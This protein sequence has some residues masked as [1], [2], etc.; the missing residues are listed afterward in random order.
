MLGGYAGKMLF[1]NLSEG[2]IREEAL[3]EEIGR[4]FIGGYG[5]GIRI[6]YERMQP[7]TDALGDGNMLGFVAG[8]LTGTSVPGSGRYGVVTKSPLTGAWSESNAGGTFG[9]A[10][11]AAGYD[12]VFFSGIAPKP[13]YLLLQDG[14][15]A[16]NDAGFL[17]GKDTYAT[18]DAIHEAIGDPKARIAS[19]GPAGEARSLLAGIVNEKGRIAARGGAGAVMGSKLLK[20]VAISGG[21]RRIAVANR[22]GLKAAQ[23]RFLD[24]IRNSEF[25]KGLTAAGTGGAVSFLISI[26]DSPVQNW[27]RT[28]SD[29]MPTAARLDSPNMDKYK[30]SPYACQACPIRCGAI[31]EQTEGPFSVAGEMHRPEYE[32]IAA[33]GNLLV[34]DNLEAVIKANDICNRY[35][36][37]TISTGTAIALAMECFEKGLI[38]ARDADGLDL[39]WG[40]AESIVALTEK[41][42][43]REGFGAVLADGPTI[44]AERIGRGAERYAVAVRGK[45]LPFHDPRMSPAGATAL[46]ADAN[47]GHHMANQ[48]AG[49]LENGISIGP[50][51]ALQAPAANPFSDFDRKGDI[52]ATGF[53]YHQLLD[54]AGLCALYTVNTTPP[55][56]A[57]LIAGVTGWD[58]GWEE[59]L[60]AGRRVLTLRQA[61]NARE[62]ITPDQVRLPQRIREELLPVA[63]GAPPG[64]DF[65]ALRDGYY[66]AMGWDTRTGI[67][68]ERALED[69]GLKDLTRDLSSIQR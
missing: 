29:S 34:N 37:D 60:K 31:I 39:S 4:R 6:L 65:D 46:F 66:R 38:T 1:V 41:I 35:A 45:G 2:S 28:G 36:I 43:K 8:V 10:M 55:D 68:S 58:Y 44:A 50:D 64:I 54:S 12:A 67:P 25:A 13:V 52:Y 18:E 49:M 63:Q 61:F 57:A 16:L 21:G 27:R 30:K 11:K 32:T 42:A 48:A 56:V 53:A 47:P 51:P 5:L 9:P 40:N 69:L 59:A 24:V 20:A 17:W 14:K 62:G 22:E 33:L 26:G 19:I 7:R 23:A 3:S 15:P